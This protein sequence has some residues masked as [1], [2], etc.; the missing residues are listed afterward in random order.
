MF[1]FVA[2]VAVVLHVNAVVFVFSFLI[3]LL[4]IV[5]NLKCGIKL[6]TTA[7][8]NETYLQYKKHQTIG[9]DTLVDVL[10]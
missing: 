9:H 4:S 7:Q 1:H 6:R 3:L 5:F 8:I 2:V 10:K